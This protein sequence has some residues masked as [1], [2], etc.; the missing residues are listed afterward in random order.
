[1]RRPVLGILAI[2]REGGVVPL[3]PWRRCSL[4]WAGMLGTAESRK[5]DMPQATAM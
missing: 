5:Q 2:R 3:K 1:M 4:H